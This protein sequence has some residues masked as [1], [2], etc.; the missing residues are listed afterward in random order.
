MNTAFTAPFQSDARQSTLEDQAHQA[1]LDHA[2]VRTPASPQTLTRI[3]DFQRQLFSSRQA[4]ALADSFAHNPGLE[5][6]AVVTNGK[7]ERQGQ[8]TFEQFCASCH[9]GPTLA[10]NEDARF[11]PVGARGPRSQGAEELINIFVQTPRPPPPIAPPPAPAT[12]HFFDGLPSADLPIMELSVLRP[13][14]TRASVRSSD[15]GRLLISG[16]LRENGRFA[17][18][19]LFGAAATAPY[20]HDNSAATLEAVIEQYQALFKLMAFLDVEA[21]LFAPE[22]N[23]QGCARGTCKFAPIPEADIPG[24]LAY[25]RQL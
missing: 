12:P 7:L 20:F 5:Q 9:G 2:E 17:V 21:G 22:T 6:A 3:A 23:G 13:D 4:R 18:P 25:L 15:A 16:D 24:L 14:S 1:M 11:L 19:T 8:R 10:V